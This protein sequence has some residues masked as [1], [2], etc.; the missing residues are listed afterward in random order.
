[1][2]VQATIDEKQIDEMEMAITFT[3]KVK[4]WEEL[5]IAIPRGYVPGKVSRQIQQVLKHI[6]DSTA[7]TFSEE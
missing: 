4:Q 6:A 1:M 3:M 7:I 2:K 5:S